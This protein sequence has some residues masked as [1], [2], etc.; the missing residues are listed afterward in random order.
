MGDKNCLL[1]AC[2]AGQV[3]TLYMLQSLPDDSYFM[4]MVI[5]IMEWYNI[6]AYLDRKILCK[7]NIIT[8]PTTFHF[9][10]L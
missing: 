2:K 5:P 9:D 10:L 4:R 7:L 1:C 6:Y 8:Q 3:N